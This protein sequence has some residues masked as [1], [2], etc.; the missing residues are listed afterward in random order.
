MYRPQRFLCGVHLETDGDLESYAF[1]LEDTEG[2]NGIQVCK[3]FPVTAVIVV[4]PGQMQRWVC[5]GLYP[6]IKERT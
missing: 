3:F 6:C 4:T 2:I 5:S 1:K